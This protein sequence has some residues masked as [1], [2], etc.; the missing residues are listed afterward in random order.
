MIFTKINGQPCALQ[1]SSTFDN[2]FIPYCTGSS[3]SVIFLMSFFISSKIF[4]FSFYSCFF[5]SSLRMNTS[6]FILSRTSLVYYFSIKRK[7]I[8]TTFIFNVK[9]DHVIK[10]VARYVVITWPILTLKMSV[11]ASSRRNVWFS[12]NQL[13]VFTENQKIDWLHISRSENSDRFLASWTLAL[14]IVTTNISTDNECL[15]RIVEC[16]YELEKDEEQI[17]PRKLI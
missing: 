2:F 1:Y 4:R 12:I 15:Q 3:S 9:T 16:P 13:P 6:S 5:C 8:D 11:I 17:K 10:I 7:C 14:L